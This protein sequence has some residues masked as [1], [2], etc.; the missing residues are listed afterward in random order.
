MSVLPS[1]LRDGSGSTPSTEVSSTPVAM[2]LVW[3]LLVLS[4]QEW[5][6]TQSLLPVS[7]A[8]EEVGTAVAICLALFLAVLVAGGVRLPVIATFLLTALLAASALVPWIY[9]LGGFESLERAAR[10]TAVVL[11][12]WLLARMSADG[13]L[14]LVRVHLTVFAFLALLVVCEALAWPGNAFDPS[15][16]RLQG[17][18]PPIASPRL[19]EI[20]AVT[21]GLAATMG[22]FRS[23]RPRVAVV[24]ASLGGSVL[25]LSHTRTATVALTIGLIVGFGAAAARRPEARAAL[26]AISLIAVLAWSVFLTPLRVWFVRQQSTE[27]LSS[28]TGRRDMWEQVVERPLSGMTL[29]FGS[30]LGDKS[31][32]GAPIDDG[33]LAAYVEQGL[34]GVAIVGA[35][36]LM[37]GW[38]ILRARPSPRRAIAA[39]LLTFVLVS[40]I[41]ETGISDVSTYLL[42]LLVAAAVM[43]GVS[44]SSERGRG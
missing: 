24:L 35:L 4:C 37:L 10:L 44:S 27:E 1:T 33:W 17:V 25:L 39:F 28:L 32:E 15:L 38:A 30:G 23:I 16:G 41:T 7:Q 9:G 20:G 21:A 26:I 13:G 2:A 31:F 8:A 42:E 40:S 43:A 29:W 36:V 22:V 3:G 12:V 34:V 18:V 6:G 11:T 14:Q 19:G 5:Q